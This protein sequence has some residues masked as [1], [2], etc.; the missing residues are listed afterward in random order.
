VEVYD[1]GRADNGTFYY[2]ME[3]LP[4]RNLEALVDRYGSM[5]AERAIHFLRQ[6][7]G[8]LREAHTAGLLH[9]DIKPSNI[10]ACERGGVY[11]VAKLLDFGLV[12]DRGLG[13]EAGRL[14]LQGTV[15]GSPPYMA[16]EQA[17]GRTDLDVRTDIY[18][19]GG[20]GYF[21]L[22][23]MPPFVRETPMEVLLA[24]AYEPVV[25]V[26]ELHPEIPAD[27]DAVIL[28]CLSKKPESRYSSVAQ[29]EKDL[30]ACAAAGLWTEEQAEEWWRARPLTD[31][32]TQVEEMSAATARA[33]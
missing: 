13:R 10:I 20:V 18:A 19:L 8:A 12:Q 11:D 22:T 26:R 7:C 23:G 15:L 27:L 16:P 28:R 32:E 25:S 14:T 33:G 21:L 6:V 5:P 30:S 2:V 31:E 24:H 17:A 29:L 9:R 4:G 1:Y 3:Y